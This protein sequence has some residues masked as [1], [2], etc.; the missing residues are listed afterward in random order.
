MPIP[1]ST[2]IKVIPWTDLVTAAPKIVEQARKIAAAA[3]RSR[4][5]ADAT[6]DPSPATPPEPPV[7]LE[8]R[9]SRIEAELVAIADEEVSTAELLKSLADQNAQIVVALQAVNARVR[10]LTIAVAV[11]AALSC[12]LVIWLALSHGSGG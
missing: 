12:G 7:T 1:W 8:T 10:R 2:L 6:T 4:T 9:V 11:L 5:E 3:R